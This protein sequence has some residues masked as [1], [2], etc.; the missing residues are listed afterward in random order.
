MSGFV[1]GATT[2]GSR[3]A[4][5]AQREKREALGAGDGWR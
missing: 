3:A 1:Q 4:S 5:R 2:G